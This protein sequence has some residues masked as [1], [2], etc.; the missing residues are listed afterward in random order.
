MAWLDDG[1]V[2]H[3]CLQPWDTEYTRLDL[4]RRWQCDDCGCIWRLDEV[5]DEYIRGRRIRF[6]LDGT[7]QVRIPDDSNAVVIDGWVHVQGASGLEPLL[8]PR[9]RLLSAAGE[10]GPVP[11]AT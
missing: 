1:W 11:D 8:S 7:D 5:E 6:V 2:I 4:G 10:E 3:H 9:G